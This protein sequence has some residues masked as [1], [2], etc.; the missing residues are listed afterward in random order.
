MG[1]DSEHGGIS[2]HRCVLHD[3][4]AGVDVGREIG[5]VDDED[6]RQR[7]VRAVPT[8]DLV[9]RGHVDHVDEEVFVVDSLGRGDRR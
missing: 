3:L 5:L 9:A 8:W 6:V 1:L 7:D 2:S 4:E